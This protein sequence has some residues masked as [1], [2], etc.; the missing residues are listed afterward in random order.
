MD[1]EIH[2]S[3]LVKIAVSIICGSILGFEREYRNKTAGF[4]TIILICLGSTIFT[5]VSES[6][7]G[8]SDD[9]I[10][11][12]IITGV[13]FIG[14]GVIFKDNLSITGLTTAAVIWVAAAIG[15]VA[16]V[17]DHYLALLLS[18]VVLIILSMF[19]WIEGVIDN[20]HHRQTFIIKFRDAELKK[21]EEAE[22]QVRKEGLDLKRLQV[23]KVNEALV[24]TVEISGKKEK[25]L[26]IVEQLIAQPN[27]RQVNQTNASNS[28]I[29][30]S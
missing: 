12:N 22:D 3:D 20:L 27:I 18:L 19:K 25:I 5:M 16:G 7:M 10:A 4:R 13:G 11:A 2:L 21:L 14:A 6:A 30:D 28:V 1:V 15:M 24:V 23:A 29:L 8:E 26:T 9:R 17:G